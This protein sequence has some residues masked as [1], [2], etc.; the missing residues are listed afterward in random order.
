M[1]VRTRLFP[2]C[3]FLLEAA[4]RESLKTTVPRIQNKDSSSLQHKALSS[5]FPFLF[6]WGEE[7]EGEGR[8]HAPFQGIQDGLRWRLSLVAS[9][10][11]NIENRSTRQS[12]KRNLRLIPKVI[13]K[14]QPSVWEVVKSWRMYIVS[15]VRIRKIFESQWTV[16]TK[17]SAVPKHVLTWS[18]S[19]DDA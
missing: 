17:L 4:G 18:A 15:D 16:K 6:F 12:S 8:S 11:V 2:H 5:S 10:P 13:L 19:N 9:V 3:G 7:Q 1:W 14:L